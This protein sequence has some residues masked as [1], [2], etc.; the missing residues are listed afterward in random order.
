M[1][2][3]RKMAITVFQR[4]NRRG[5]S[6]RITRNQNDLADIPV[7]RNISSLAMTANGDE[8]LMY[9]KR[10]WRGGVMFRRGVQTINNLGSRRQ[11]GRNTFR[12][13]IASVRVTPFFL[14]LNVTVVTQSDG[15]LPGTDTSMA[16]ITARV[17]NVVT[18]VNRFYGLQQALLEVGVAQIN[19]RVHDNKFNL[20]MV[21][22][23]RFPNSWKNRDEIDVILVNSFDGG[24]TGLAKSPWAGKVTIVAMRNNGAQRPNNTIAKTLAHEIGHFL[25]S[26]HTEANRNIMTQGEFSIVGA[27]ANVEQM[28]EWHTKLSR[29]LTRRRNRQGD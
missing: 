26:P 5:D 11:G 19:Q 3:E 22:A 16:Q 4:T 17:N 15:T 21:E 7:G 14:P 13:N 12:N 24:F 28:Q 9:K 27:N 18:L 10:N 6:A 23:A 1:K 20:S 29:N 8:I 25:G 2:G